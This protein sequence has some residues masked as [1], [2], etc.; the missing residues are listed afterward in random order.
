MHKGCETKSQAQLLQIED[1]VW[2]KTVSIGDMTHDHERDISLS[3]VAIISTIGMY[4][5]GPNFVQ[6]G[7]LVADV[8]SS[9]SMMRLR[10]QRL[11]ARNKKMI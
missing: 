5:V 1:L 10:A 3:E 8:Q 6:F 9:K 4:H 7:S 2:I 11:L